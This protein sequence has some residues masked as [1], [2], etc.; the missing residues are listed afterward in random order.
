MASQGYRDWLN[1]GRPYTLIRPAKAV[2]AALRGYGLT[3]YDYPNDAHL[4]ANTPEDHTPFSVTGWPGPN[5]RWKARALDVMPRSGS[6]THRKENADIA[7]QLIRDRDAGV[8][9]AMWIKYI[10]WTDENGTCRQERW[11]DAARPLARTTRSST[12]KGHIHIS[13]R[14]DVDD[15]D[16]ADGYDPMARLQGRDYSVAD[17]Q[18]IA[19][20]ERG[21]TALVAGT[22]PVQFDFPWNEQASEG[23]PNPLR[24][25][26]AKL[27][28]LIAAAAADET[29]DVAAV[30]AINSLVA[31]IQ[32]GG[33]SI[34]AEPIIAAIEAVRAQT[35]AEVVQLQQELAAARAENQEL[36]AALQAANAGRQPDSLSAE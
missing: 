7:R 22:D 5:K 9:G 25:M 2:Q 33:A 1:A 8:D 16:R 23:F 29:R 35:H 34:S 13:G 27:D 19:N 21:I 28:T 3:V 32:T 30:A 18:L 6:A 24:Q 17:S 31:T 4:Q 11:M 26:T 15:D 14:S 36:R 20:A 12:D 10:N